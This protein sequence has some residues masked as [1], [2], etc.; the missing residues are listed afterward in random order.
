[1]AIYEGRYGESTNG[2]STPTATYDSTQ[3]PSAST[4]P[5]AGLTLSGDVELT[6]SAMGLIKHWDFPFPGYPTMLTA[7]G[8]APDLWGRSFTVLDIGG[9]P[10]MP[11]LSAMP[12]QST[13]A[14]TW[15]G[16]LG[17]Q[18]D[19]INNPYL[20]NLS[21]RV[22]R[23]VRPSGAL[24]NPFTP[25]ELERLLRAYDSDAGVLAPRLAALLGAASLSTAASGGSVSAAT[26]LRR[27]VTNDSFDLPSP[28]LLAVNTTAALTRAALASRTV[29]SPAPF[30]SSAADLLTVRIAAAGGLTGSNVDPMLTS[31]HSGWNNLPIQLQLMLPPE[32]LNGQRFDIN[33]PFGNGR[34]D[35]QRWRGR[36][37][38][39]ILPGRAGL[40]DPSCRR[41]PPMNSGNPS[42]PRSPTKLR[43]GA[44][45]PTAPCN[46]AIDW[47]GDGTINQNDALMA[48]HIM[49]RHFYVL[50]MMLIDPAL[51]NTNEGATL[52]VTTSIQ[53]DADTPNG[54]RSAIT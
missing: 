28:N 29:L 5:Y 4:P 10:L 11:S 1:M 16:G 52:N 42:R 7:Y 25:G 19:T 46:L 3:L 38:R 45:R 36:R 31:T 44:A 50:A 17:G 23:G 43:P 53:Y 13:A 26:L 2:M 12:F 39:R 40:D 24:D 47:N 27:Q 37:A 41:A 34:D 22:M 18:N 48:R 30:A 54:P 9:M 35:D 15:S 49:A 20:L 33:R 21:R 32:L 6:A 8:S 51:L 14:S